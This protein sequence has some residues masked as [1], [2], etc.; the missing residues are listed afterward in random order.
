MLLEALLVSRAWYRRRRPGIKLL[1]KEEEEEEEEE[2]DG[3]WNG[4]A[5][6][7]E[8]RQLGKIRISVIAALW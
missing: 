4:S 2:E 1:Q 7:R 6:G 5:D 3:K 8:T